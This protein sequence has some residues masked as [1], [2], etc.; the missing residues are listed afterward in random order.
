ML[1][2]QHFLP[3]STHN[4]SDYVGSL[5]DKYF[6]TV[7]QKHETAKAHSAMTWVRVKDAAKGI[8][9]HIEKATTSAVDTVQKVSGLK[10]RE[11][12]GW[13]RAVK[14]K[15]EDM[16]SEADRMGQDSSKPPEETK[17]S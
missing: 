12:L 1:S 13:Q 6:P 11:T 5:E 3:K 4:L 15:M 14:A 17:E 16:K 10:L 7:A 8:N 9:V 2:A